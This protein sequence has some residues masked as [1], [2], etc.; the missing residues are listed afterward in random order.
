MLQPGHLGHQTKKRA[1]AIQGAAPPI[2]GNVL[3]LVTPAAS[4]SESMHMSHNSGSNPLRIA[5]H[6]S[7]Q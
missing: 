7:R 1:L 2:P 5:P 6:P 4:A 3:S